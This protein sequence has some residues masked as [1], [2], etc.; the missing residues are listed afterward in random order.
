[1]LLRSFDEDAEQLP[2]FAGSHVFPIYP[3]ARCP[4]PVCTDVAQ[5][6]SGVAEGRRA[7]M[8]VMKAILG[9]VMDF[10]QFVHEASQI[11]PLRRYG[12]GNGKSGAS[13]VNGSASMNSVERVMWNSMDADIS[14]HA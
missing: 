4:S 2:W 3:M 6:K 10:S 5:L 11:V 1:M 12:A 9:D 8:T 14:Q 7:T 13:G